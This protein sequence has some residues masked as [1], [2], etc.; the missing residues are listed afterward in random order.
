MTIILFKWSLRQFT[1][2]TNCK[3]YK[4]SNVNILRPT[5]NGLQNA[6]KDEF[7]IILK[8]LFNQKQFT[9]IIWFIPEHDHVIN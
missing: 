1:Q 5:N 2:V 6:L 9:A 4:Q 8:S 3:R 7:E